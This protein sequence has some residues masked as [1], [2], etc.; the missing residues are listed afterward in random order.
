MRKITKGFTLIEL[1]I[2]VLIVGI[3]ASFAFPNYRDYVIRAQN[4]D[5]LSALNSTKLKLEQFYQDNRTYSGACDSGSRAHPPTLENFTISCDLDSNSYSISATGNGFVYTINEQ[6]E[7]STSSAPS[8][9]STSDECWIIN[10]NG[11]C[12]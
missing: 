12:Q 8:G 9:W 4:A 2:T 6:N 7:R 5:A 11:T 10:K 3:I 1:M